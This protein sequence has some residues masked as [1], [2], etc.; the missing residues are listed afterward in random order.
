M[1][2]RGDE[3]AVSTVIGAVLL[4]G[5]VVTALALYQVNVVP[6]EN[7]AVEYEHNQQTQSQL[8]ELRNTIVSVPGGGNGGADSVSL[9]TNYPSRTMTVNPPPS[10]GTLA[11]ESL[12]EIVIE[13]AT[14]I[15]GDE[16]PIED[17]SR[18]TY[19]L[20]YTPGYN[21]YR[22]A[23]TTVLEHGFL[24]NQHP[25]NATIPLDNQIVIDGEEITIVTMTGNLSTSSSSS[26]SV[27]T[28]A[29]ST[30]SNTVS[31]D[32]VDDDNPITM[33]LPTSNFEAWNESLRESDAVLEGSIEEAGTGEQPAIRFQLVDQS[34]SLQMAEVGIGDATRASAAD[35]ATYLYPVDD[36]A[37]VVTGEIRDELNNP[38]Q[39]VP[40]TVEVNGEERNQPTT[41]GSNGQLEI[42]NVSEGDTVT[43][44]VDG[45]DLEQNSFVVEPSSSGD[46]GSGSSGLYDIR[47]SEDQA[48]PVEDCDEVGCDVD[49]RVSQ[50]AEN[51]RFTAESDASEASADFSY[52]EKNDIGIRITDSSDF[53]ESGNAWVE[54]N[55]FNSEGVFD[56]FIYSGGSSDQISVRV[57]EVVRGDVDVQNEIRETDDDFEV[58]TS[59]FEHLDPDTGGYLVVDNG[60]DEVS[61]PEVGED[62]VTV[63]DL[64][65]S[66]GEELTARLYETSTRE[67]EL[68]SDTT[69]VLGEDAPF[70]DVTITDTNSPV[71]EGET[72]TIDVEV[73]NTGGETATQEIDLDI[74]DGFYT[75][76]ITVD[77]LES[78]GTETVTFEWDTQS[79][80]AGDYTATVLSDG[81]GDT[82]EI[83]I[84]NHGSSGP[85]EFEG[86]EQTTG[87]NIEFGISNSEENTV[88]IERISVDTQLA[89]QVDYG[90]D[91]EVNITG[92]LQNGHIDTRG[93]RDFM[94][95]GTSYDLAN[96]GNNGQYAILA[97]DDTATVDIRRLVN[98]P[99]LSGLQ[100]TTEANADIT[101]ILTLSVNGEQ[102]TIEQ[103][104]YFEGDQ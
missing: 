104:F 74:G 98:D 6:D 76:T 57:S 91:R 70:F 86:N 34:Y 16:V 65:F 24:Y 33:T 40:V 102:D 59:N 97:S 23:P 48:E 38:V 85:L 35:R 25:N 99:D 3:R 47:W 83:T 9:G 43:V 30:S 10:S 58:T 72:L 93:N 12:G 32:Q 13:N 61:F 36:R 100:I 11:S 81:D 94:A 84:L 95:D 7:Q 50:D 21:E 96:D 26:V 79:G 92:G 17:W 46:G 56:L 66:A 67:N 63:S 78:G 75:D 55:E 4:L 49:Y 71:L 15:D 51:V 52:N 14:S 54:L 80:D 101:V 42:K 44:S 88:T 37:P 87:D 18:E 5:I 103:P 53:D 60:T 89:E 22:N 19:G 45:G 62:T 20:T 90:N 28:R 77:G 29:F 82:V 31:V 73:H 68:D 1:I 39:N 27:Q 69:E 8:Q 41:T 2:D 64:E